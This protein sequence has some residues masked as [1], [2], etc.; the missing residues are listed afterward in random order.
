MKLHPD[1][2][3]LT[4]YLL[5]ELSAH[6]T[7]AVEHAAA[8]D[9][10]IRLAL[11]DLTS[12]QRLLS[13]TLASTTNTLLPHQREMVRRKA[14]E[15]DQAGKVVTLASQ[16]R[17]WK[18]WLV[19]LSAA[20]LI[21]LAVFVLIH[22]PAPDGDKLANHP[23]PGPNKDWGRIPLEIALL[24]A[25]GPAD[26]SRNAGG[27]GS[28]PDPAPG[29]ATDS[30]LAGQAAARDTALAQTGDE[31]L[32]RV[33]ER[34]QQS[35]PPAAAALPA[36]TRRS[37]VPASATPTLALPIHAGRASLGWIT[38][39]VRNE[40]KL[41]SPNAVRLEELLNAFTLRPAG[42]AAIAQGVSIAT[43]SLPCPWK[44]SASLL[45]ISIRGAADSAREVT[46]TFH[47]DPAAVA[48]YRL[49]GFAPI[50]G[51]SPGPLPS[52][53]PAKAITTLALEIEPSSAA[54]ALGA[55]EWTVDGKPAA[56]VPINL[57]LDAEP[58]DDARFASLVCTYA[59]WLVHDQPAL[60]DAELLAALAR[61]T[62]SATLPT[63]RA[64]LL[65]LIAQSLALKDR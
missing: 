2:P 34:L 39:A 50:S 46:A 9:P 37:S 48:L 5:G 56:A 21:T 33:A 62:A 24:P 29:T 11:R 19:P 51:L 14:R 20:A 30:A 65:T 17:S 32:H 59:Q 10:A 61:E 36:L 23:T 8:V 35:P 45:L 27:T 15:A 31:F 43:E 28:D 58:S 1:D 49:L 54:T 47:A 7:A 4:A 13:N 16:R 60:I 12:V 52:R 25:P 22:S 41:P 53:L 64:D 3:R 44:P 18:S 26:A 6:E 55:I 63:D 38:Q 40:H 42:S 57:H